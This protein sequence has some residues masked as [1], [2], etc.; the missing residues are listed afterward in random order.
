MAGAVEQPEALTRL[1][2]RNQAVPQE[3]LPG[4]RLFF[5]VDT[6]RY[7]FY[8]IASSSIPLFSFCEANMLKSVIVSLVIL[9]ASFANAGERK[10]DQTFYTLWA[11][12]QQIE[13]FT[14][15]TR[16]VPKY[17]RPSGLEDATLFTPAI[18][19]YE[20]DLQLGR[21][22]KFK[23]EEEYFSLVRS[24]ASR[25]KNGQQSRHAEIIIRNEITVKVAKRDDGLY[26]AQ[27]LK[28]HRPCGVWEVFPKRL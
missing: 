7:M 6:T 2:N 11:C 20:H 24:G 9:L 8:Y 17:A 10:Y 26:Y 16:L 12:E 19:E 22:L 1:R 25:D 27:V 23:S 14:T 13:A 28:K 4:G 3:K 15:Y 18:E 21:A 5:C